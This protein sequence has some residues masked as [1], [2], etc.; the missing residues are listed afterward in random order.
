MAKTK[1]EVVTEALRHIGVVS[2]SEEP[3]AADYDAA[4]GHYDSIFDKLG[5]V[6]EVALSFT[7]N[8]VD[9]WAFLPLAR[10]VAGS[11]CVQFSKPQFVA[12]YGIGLRDIIAKSGNDTRVEGVPVKV[13]YF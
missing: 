7:S 12:E 13:E 11:V 5:E 9:D 1:R 4:A 8:A 6:H 3:T 2:G 10:M